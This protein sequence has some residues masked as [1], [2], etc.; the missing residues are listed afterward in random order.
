MLGARKPDTSHSAFLDEGDITIGELLALLA[1]HAIAKLAFTYDARP[2]RS[3]Y[4]VTEVKFGRFSA[5]DCGA[6]IEA[7]NEVF[8]QLWDVDDSPTQMT[9]GK[10]GAILRKVAEQVFLDMDARLTFEVSDSVRPMQ[11]FCAGAPRIA[12]DEI[13]VDLSPRSAS[14]KPR[15]R[16]LEEKRSTAC[17]SSASVEPCRS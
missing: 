7:W 1:D 14:C 6:A 10:F 4:H 11:L 5:L 12:E 9:A 3:G 17:C 16:W 2:I 15:D 13:V 8:V